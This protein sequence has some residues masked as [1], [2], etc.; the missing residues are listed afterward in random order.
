MSRAPPQR[1]PRRDMQWLAPWLT[2]HVNAEGIEMISEWT[3]HLPR[4]RL[5][6]VVLVAAATATLLA[7]S[8]TT[9]LAAGPAP[10]GGIISTVAGGVGGPGA[11]TGISL[12]DANGP[13]CRLPNTV[14]FAA[15]NLYIAEGSVRKVSERTGLLTTPAGTG[16]AGPLGTGGPAVS[17]PLGACGV[18]V[19]HAGNLVIADELRH[20]IDVVPARTG[21]FYGRAMSA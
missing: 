17:A 15:G 20:R 13:A 14:T 19:D 12:S 21:E 9:A 1:D 2:A 3:S 4:H 5:A 18:A 7:G 10:A 16:A 6:G 8:G 11:G